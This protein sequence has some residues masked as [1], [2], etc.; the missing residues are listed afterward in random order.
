MG[1]LSVEVSQVRE[2][3][4]PRYCRAYCPEGKNY[5]HRNLANMNLKCWREKSS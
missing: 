4:E 5:A 3:A 1:G 2:G